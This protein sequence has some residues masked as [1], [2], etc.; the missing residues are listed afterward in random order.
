MYYTKGTGGPH[1]GIKVNQEF[2]SLL[3]KIF[4]AQ[5]LSEYRKQYPSDWTS[6]MN[7]FEIKKWGRRVVEQQATTIRLPCSFLTLINDD[8]KMTLKRHADGEIKIRNNDNLCLDSIVMRKLFQ[9]VLGA[10]KAHLKALLDEPRLSKVTVMLLVGE[11]AN[12]LL[13]QEGFKKEFSSRC[14]VVY[15]WYG[16]IAIVQGA[17]LLARIQTK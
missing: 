9:P 4:G 5:K 1:G 7:D 14:N 3:D 13:L 6:L 2:K 12:S 11:F 17:V 8:V 10:I 15:P 16:D